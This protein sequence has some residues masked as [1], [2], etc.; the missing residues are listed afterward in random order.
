MF[1]V[2]KKCFLNNEEGINI[3]ALLFDNKGFELNG[4]NI[5]QYEA[6]NRK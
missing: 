3:I 4:R 6:I 5:N 1:F 2:E